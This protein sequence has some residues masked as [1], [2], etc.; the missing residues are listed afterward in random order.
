[1]LNI[2]DFSKYVQAFEGHIYAVGGRMV[3]HKEGF[4]PGETVG[5]CPPA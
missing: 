2:I 3:G 1:M 5:N 4:N